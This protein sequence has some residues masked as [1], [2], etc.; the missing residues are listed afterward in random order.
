MLAEMRDFVKTLGVG[1]NFSI[2]KIDSSKDKSIGLY[3]DSNNR[4]IEAMNRLSSYDVTNMRI[5]VH[6]NKNLAESEAA[7][8]S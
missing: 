4:R 2:G 5:L 6:W 7:A 1:E 8:R 3:G